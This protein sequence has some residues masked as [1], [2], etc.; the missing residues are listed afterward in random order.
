M[1]EYVVDLLAATTSAVLRGLN[2][3]YWK[4][5]I[6]QAFS[7]QVVAC[8]L[9]MIVLVVLLA[10]IIGSSLIVQLQIWV[11]R[12]G[13]SH[14]IGSLLVIVVLREIAP[15]VVNLML[16]GR[17][18]SAMTAELAS[19]RLAGEVRVLEAQGIDPFLYLVVPRVLGLAVSGLFL[20]LLFVLVCLS[21]GYFIGQFTEARTG[22]IFEF[23]GDVIGG[24]TLSDLLNLLA[25]SM[26]IPLLI[27]TTLCNE[28]LGVASPR[29]LPAAIRRGLTQAVLIA[30][31]ASSCVSLLIYS[32]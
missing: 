26:F 20:T 23:S 29:E 8:G 3:R 28:G 1:G 5:L 21:S 16:I 10:V 13:Q 9:K 14:M 4:R 2:P 11:T 32:I 15:L 7:E 17:S 18:G 31:I 19:M 27:G 12:I 25:K 30:F 22:G 6:R 24:L